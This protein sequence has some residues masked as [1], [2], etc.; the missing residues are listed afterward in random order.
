M[1]VVLDIPARP[2]GTV[3]MLV[4]GEEGLIEVPESV[5]VLENEFS[6]TFMVAGLAPG[7]TTVTA[8]TE[9]GELTTTVVLE[10]PMLGFVLSEVYYD[11]PGSDTG[12]EWVELFNGTAE[13]IDLS[14]YSLGNAGTNYSTSTV[15]L[16]G[17]LEPGQCFVVGG[18]ISDE[19]SANAVY[20]QAFDFEPDFQN[21]GNAADGVALFA[22]PA[23]QVNNLTVP[24]D[25]VLYG[26]SN[27]NGLMD[28]T[29]EAGEPD[30]GDVSSG[31][32]LERGPEG[33]HAQPVPTPNDCT[34]L[35]TAN[36]E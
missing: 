29:G 31:S 25:A 5:T 11:P 14:G 36:G 20:A 15:Q 33:W 18:P 8:S 24:M 3:V 9:G 30:V 4:A 17:T 26:P 21:S 13:A 1:A 2:G 27:D 23:N 34:P 16:S 22:V 35:W 28:E 12:R 32:S 6:A 19:A 10:I 7:S